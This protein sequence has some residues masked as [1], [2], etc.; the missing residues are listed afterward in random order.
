MSLDMKTFT[1]P[2]K[3]LSVFIWHGNCVGGPANVG[4]ARRGGRRPTLGQT[5]GVRPNGAGLSR[6]DESQGGDRTGGGLGGTAWGGH[7]PPPG[8]FATEGE[9]AGIR[10]SAGCPKVVKAATPAADR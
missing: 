9:P 10:R 6:E 3:M 8:W 5:G 2:Q 4:V 7:G 1:V